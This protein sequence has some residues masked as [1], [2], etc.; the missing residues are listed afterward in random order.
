[1]MQKVN[2]SKRLINNGKF[3]PNDIA[4]TTHA[5]GHPATKL[6]GVKQRMQ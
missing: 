2:Q 4:K 6:R 5:R 1:M 3:S